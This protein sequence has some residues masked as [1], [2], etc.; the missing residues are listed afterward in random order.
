MD[1]SLLEKRIV[2][3]ATERFEEEYSKFI[4]FLIS[5]EFAKFVKI[6]VGVPVIEGRQEKSIPLAYF[7]CNWGIFNQEQ[8]NNRN[9]KFSNYEE[10]KKIMIEN[11]IKEETD[12]LLNQLSGLKDF[13][14]PTQ[15]TN[16][17]F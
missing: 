15:N 17:E 9:K 12:A 16:D 7:G 10:I 14:N 4:K 8:R 1:K 3:K 2:E 5:N 11:F 6:D 13:L